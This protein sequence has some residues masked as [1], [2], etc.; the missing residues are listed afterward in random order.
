ML[1]IYMS[2]SIRYYIRTTC[3]TTYI[4]IRFSWSYIQSLYRNSAILLR[5]S[6][7]L[8]KKKFSISRSV[9]FLSLKLNTRSIDRR[10]QKYISLDKSRT[11]TR[12]RYKS[13]S[14]RRLLYIKKKLKRK[15]G[16]IICS[17]LL[18]IERSRA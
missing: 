8:E 13:S 9:L 16:R 18:Y 17:R 11:T 14:K 1:Y 3:S 5:A 15:K 4:Y 10:K 6:V 12:S 7:S 2:A